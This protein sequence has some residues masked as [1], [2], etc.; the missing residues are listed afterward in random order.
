[1][2]TVEVEGIEELLQDWNEGLEAVARGLDTG[3][4]LG[5][6]EGI[7]EAK[8]TRRYQDRTGDLTDGLGSQLT[9]G[10]IG[11]SGG[12]IAGEMYAMAPYSRYV[13]DGTKPHEIR[14]KKGGW[15][16]WEAPQGDWHFAKVVQHPGTKPYGF[17]TVAF[18]KCEAV[19]VRETELG[20]ER[21]RRIIEG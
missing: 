10:G 4:R 17:M 18:F 21:L 9:S 5:I 6:R 7:D 13:N 20:I 16:A 15:L 1:M 2:L 11:Y 8:A 19:I 14:A 3:V 12:E